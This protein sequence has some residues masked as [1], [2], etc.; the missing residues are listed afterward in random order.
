MAPAHQIILAVYLAGCAYRYWQCC[1]HLRRAMEKEPALVDN[2]TAVALAIML[3]MLIS[4]PVALTW[5]I[6]LFR[7][8]FLGLKEP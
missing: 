7:V 2:P 1:V 4:I 5:P 3:N 8:H 6:Y